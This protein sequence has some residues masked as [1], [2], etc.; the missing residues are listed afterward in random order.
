VRDHHQLRDRTRG[1]KPAVYADGNIHATEVSPTTACT[2]LIH[3]LLTRYGTDETVTRALDTRAFYIIPRVNPD[4]AEVFLS[5]T[6]RYLRS[7]TRPYPFD[8]EPL[9]GLKREDV[10]GDGLVLQMRVPDPNGA[11]K[12]H[13]DD[14]RLLVRRDPTETGGE[15]FRCSPRDASPTTTAR[16]RDAEDE[17]GTGPEPELSN[18]WRPEHEQAGAGPYPTSE[19]RPAPSSTF[20]AEPPQHLRRRHVSYVFGRFAPSLRHPRRRR[21]PRRGS[22]GL[23]GD[24][25]ERTELTGYPACS[26]FH[27][28]KYHPKSVITGVFDDWCYDQFGIFAWTTEIWS[29]Q[30]QAGITEGFS[31]D[32]KQG[33]FKFTSWGRDH[34]PADDLAMVRWADT[35]LGARDTTTGR[36]SSIRTSARS[37][38]VDGTCSTPSE[39]PRRSSGV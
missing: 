16:L 31:K 22:V 4:G 6:P 11:W 18:Q 37:R 19:P 3:K 23:S 1:E 5:D 10:N 15:Y 36:P 9:D 20:V 29:P 25:Q 13:G 21:V 32:T 7:S 26:V 28:F 35:H 12:K 30:R 8:E 14:A 39:T 34:D 33:A 2:Y 27:D 17:R 24:R 38:S